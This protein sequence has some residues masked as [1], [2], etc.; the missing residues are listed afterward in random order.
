MNKT[1]MKRLLLALALLVSPAI[2]LVHAQ[3]K[4]TFVNDTASPIVLSPN[5]AGVNLFA[6]LYGGTNS[7]SLA[8]QNPPVLVSG[9]NIPPTSVT[10]V[11]SRLTYFQV[12][13]WD[14][15]VPSYEQALAAGAFVGVGAVFTMNVGGFLPVRTAPPSINSTWHEGPIVVSMP[16]Q[17]PGL[18]N[19]QWTNGAFQFDLYGSV[20]ATY[21]VEYSES[22]PA[23]TWTPLTNLVLITPL[24]GTIVDTSAS[25]SDQRFYRAFGV[26]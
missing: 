10:L 22:L 2:S 19:L 9:S 1:R 26:Q 23:A 12:K 16:V 24:P 17:P 13:V 14:S 15:A 7:D 21:Y 11:P 4:V 8:P 25:A 3:S 6:A 20:G 18:S 5:T